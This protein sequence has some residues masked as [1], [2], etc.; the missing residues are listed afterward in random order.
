M[1]LWVLLSLSCTGSVTLPVHDEPLAHAPPPPA[2]SLDLVEVRAPRELRGLWVAT[3]A[4]LDFPTRPGLSVEAQ[5]AELDALVGRT[6]DLGFNA[7]V[8]QVRPEG[9]AF[10][11]S[12]LEPW[13]R[14]LTGQQGRDPGFDPLA[15]LVDA[16]HARGVEVH[17]WFNPYR[18]QSS[19]KANTHSSH[20]SQWAAAHAIPWGGLLWLDPGVPEVQQ[21]AVSVVRDVVTRYDIDGVHL[22]DYFYPYPDGGKSFPDERSYQQYRAA[23]G[24]LERDDW[25]RHNVDTLVH[26]L[27][28]AVKSVRP[29]VRFGISPFGI[30]RPGYPEGIRGMD[31]YTAIFADPMAWYREGYVDYL[32]PQLYW[33]T[34]KELQ[35][36]D[37]LLGWWNEHSEAARPLVVGLD[38]TKV[39]NDSAWHLEELR[40]QIVLARGADRTA[41]HIWFRATPVL[42]NQAGVADL[43]A[44]LYRGPAL[45]PPIARITDPVPP[46]EFEADSSGVHLT[47]DRE[48][49]KGYMLYRDDAGAWAAE[50]FIP[51]V[52][53]RVDLP[54]GRYAIS[55]VSRAGVESPG[56]RLTIPPSPTGEA[57]P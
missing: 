51:R 13:S 18:A 52:M 47:D 27:A 11:A 20:I 54:P 2:P 33:P 24:Q 42:K 28:H 8:F 1:A 48:R 14:F 43:L 25:R 23:G 3:V 7:L 50:R 5:K 56:V 10:Y 57:A 53:A 9:D 31:Q 15:H 19:R 30:Y 35:R 38:L 26:E 55:A 17:A 29:D 34:T 41:G 49:L 21:H 44:D 4:N 32:A 22:D 6:A 37:R 39:G 12:E 46:P 45:P 16:A 40:T 36:Y